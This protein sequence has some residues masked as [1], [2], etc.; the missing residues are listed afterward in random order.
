MSE[1]ET[2][3]DDGREFE[4]KL[5]GMS[6]FFGVSSYLGSSGVVGTIFT[7]PFEDEMAGTLMHLFNFVEDEES[8][9]FCSV[10]FF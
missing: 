7:P 4:E 6:I 10:V 9:I 3:L 5:K 2:Y 8:M 1:T